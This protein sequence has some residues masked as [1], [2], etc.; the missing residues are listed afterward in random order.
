MKAIIL[1]S[2][3]GSGTTGAVAERFG[4]QFILIELNPSYVAMAVRRTENAMPLLKG[5]VA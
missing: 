4:R 1:D 2:F 5:I 3:A